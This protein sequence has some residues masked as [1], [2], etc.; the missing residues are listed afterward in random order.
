MKIII[1]GGTG[2]LGKE[3]VHH[4]EKEDNEIFVLSRGKSRIEGKT[5][6]VHWD[7]TS[8][9]AWESCL[10]GADLVINLTGKPVNCRY[11][12]SNKLEIV[13][14]RVNATRVL[15]IA[16]NKLQYKPALWINAS[17]ASIYGQHPEV[18]MTEEDSIRGEDFSAIVAQKWEAAFFQEETVNLRKVALRISL[19]LGKSGGV[20]PVFKKLARLGLGGKMGNGKQKFG[21]IHI[22]D[23]IRMIDCIIQNETISGPVNC[24]SPN[25]PTN[26]EFMKCLRK[27]LKMPFG[28]PQP[29]FLLDIGA[30]F[31]GTESELI[32]SSIYAYPKRLIDNGFKFKFEN[33]QDALNDLSK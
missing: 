32:L 14:S 3:L 23:V 2:F 9:G 30:V 17:A 4:F 18:L 24:I 27:A 25:T 1:A 21:W 22:D 6:F 13:N 8:E 15:Q 20:F 31:I 26:Q 19:I 5:N 11:T 12:E 28:L 7:A 10:I 16:V 29:K 33:C